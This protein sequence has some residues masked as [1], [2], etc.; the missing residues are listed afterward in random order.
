MMEIFN[1][2]R[3]GM[4]WRTL[5][6]LV[7]SLTFSFLVY[8]EYF[9]TYG[10]SQKR[11]LLA[12]VF[13]IV[14]FLVVRAFLS[15][16]IRKYFVDNQIRFTNLFLGGMFVSV[17]LSP[18]FAPLAHF[19]SSPMFRPTS[20]VKITIDFPKTADELIQLKGVWLNFDNEQY[21]SSNF[22]LSD[23]WTQSE[24]KYFL[25]SRSQGQL[26]WKGKIGE[27]AKLTIFPLETQAHVT[28]LWDGEEASYTL[29]DS[30]LV[31]HKKSFAPKW[32]Y[33]SLM[34]ARIIFAGIVLFVFSIIFLALDSKN[35]F[36]IIVSLL[37]LLVPLTVYSQFQDV[38]IKG[39]IDMQESRHQAVISGH[40]GNPWQYR[41]L[42]EWVIE[43]MMC[44]ARA[45]G[46]RQSYFVVFVLLRVVQNALI[47]ALVYM[48]YQKLF[49]SNLLSLLGIVFVTGSLL[50]SF[51]LSDLS[52]NTY[53][54]LIF[55][56]GAVLLA[57]N[58]SFGWIPIIMFAASLNRETSGLIPFLTLSMVTDFK[59]QKSEI[60]LS[61]FSLFIW[62]LIFILIRILYPERELIIPYGYYPGFSL[63]AFNT[64]PGWYYLMLRFFS[65]APLFGLAFYKHWSPMLKRFFIIMIPIWFVIHFFGSVISETRLFLVPQIL[66]LIPSFLFFC[67]ACVRQFIP[68]KVYLANHE[69][70]W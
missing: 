31:I 49:H 35:Q 24:R 21:S 42:S 11:M 63:L 20:I 16:I 9:Q 64:L 33:A 6:S 17:L 4:L 52:F 19:P 23:K 34:F 29:I 41:V 18:C 26:S 69:T 1:R 40:S 39:R 44:L 32:Y 68:A 37:V 27:Q 43:G 38:E 28:V 54:D 55:Y 8:M 67:S 48:Y 51:Y 47:Y 2:K 25:D 61:L 56:L 59:K 57:L 65:L 5:I 13:V 46:L 58:H 50:N 66:V 30:P 70:Q 7:F 12:L 15:L 60:F 14:L 53:S 3:Y 36:F 62:G 22:Y 45:F 10:F